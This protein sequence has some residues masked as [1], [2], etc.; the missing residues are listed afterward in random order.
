MWKD[1]STAV[2]ALVMDDVLY[3]ANLGDSKV[4]YEYAEMLTSADLSL[5]VF[6]LCQPPYLIFNPSLPQRWHKLSQPLKKSPRSTHPTKKK[7]TCF[8]QCS[9]KMHL[10]ECVLATA[11]SLP[12]DSQIIWR[13]WHIENI[14][15]TDP[16]MLGCTAVFHMCYLNF[17]ML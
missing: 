10:P 11:L 8:F 2:T 7:M 14:Y 9:M 13:S 4:I 1:G 5:E 3:V 15:C 17:F 12:P 16:N 6:S